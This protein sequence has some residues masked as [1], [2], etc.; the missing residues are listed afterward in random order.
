MYET[1]GLKKKARQEDM[2]NSG[3]RRVDGAL[4]DVSAGGFGSPERL[5]S[6]E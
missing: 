2:V 6:Y 4:R 3:T 5:R 1:R